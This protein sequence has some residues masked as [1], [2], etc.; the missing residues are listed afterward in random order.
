MSKEQSINS[1]HKEVKQRVLTRITG[2]F[3]LLLSP[4]DT[5]TSLEGRSASSFTSSSCGTPKRIKSSIRALFSTTPTDKYRYSNFKRMLSRNRKK[6]ILIKK[7]V[8]N[9]L[10]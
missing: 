9:K 2:K 6:A 1:D 4:T 8:K 3:I 10:Y 7:Y 5:T